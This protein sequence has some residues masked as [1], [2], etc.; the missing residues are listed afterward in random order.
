M[1]TQTQTYVRPSDA[2]DNGDGSIG[3][4]YGDI[5]FALEQVTRDSTNGD[6]FNVMDGGDEVLEFALDIVN[7]YGTPNENAPLVFQGMTAAGSAGDGGIGG[8]S[9]GGSVA[10][11]DSTSIDHVHFI[12][13]HL[14]NTGSAELFDADQYCSLIRCEIDNCSNTG[15]PVAL[16]NNAKII[17]CHIHNI[18]GRCFF[19]TGIASFNYFENGTNDFIYTLGSSFGLVYRNIIKIDGA[20]D[21]IS[22]RGDDAQA[23]NNSIWSNGGTG[24]GISVDSP[25]RGS[26]IINNLIEGFSGTGGKG[27]EFVNNNR[28][29][30]FAGN[31]SYNNDT[32]YET[33][34]LLL[35]DW[36][37]LGNEVLSASP[38][39]DAVNGDFKPVDTGA[40]K[41][42]SIPINFGEGQ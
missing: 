31:S 21:G 32:D 14:H 29:A 11:L 40:V 35:D 17:G 42:G 2:D 20:S 38:F 37:G 41:E 12:D 36:K 9:G 1:A 16:G 13:M 27:V 4:P 23:I 19:S 3:D 24:A 30:L 7:D 10:I 25:D 6:R 15:T 22:L 5:E 39:T 34:I 28:V 33:P 18:A 8:I 26:M